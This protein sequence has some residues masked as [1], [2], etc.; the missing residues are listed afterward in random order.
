MCS[1]SRSQTAQGEQLSMRD[2]DGHFTNFCGPWKSMSPTFY[3]GSF[4]EEED[5]L[6]LTPQP[7]IAQCSSK[8]W[9]RKDGIAY[10]EESWST[11]GYK[12]KSTNDRIVEL[13]Q[14]NCEQLLRYNGILR[15][16]VQREQELTQV[17]KVL[18]SRE[19][20][21][22]RL[23]ASFLTE[24]AIPGISGLSNC[25]Y[26]QMVMLVKYPILKLRCLPLYYIL[27]RVA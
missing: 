25:Y 3:Q 22:A 5:E 27:W 16:L 24:V 6:D 13:W 18:E 4:S 26:Q 17:K 23:K 20:V 7:T 15:F 11:G 21:L 12:L 1:N 14:E 10:K 9:R 19:L 8:L 2:K